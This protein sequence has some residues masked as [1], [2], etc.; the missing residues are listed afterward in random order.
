M[1]NYFNINKSDLI[2]DKVI[3]TQPSDSLLE[4]ITN[5]A[6]Q[7][8]ANN[9]KTVLRTSEELLEAQM[10]KMKTE[11]PQ[12]T[13]KPVSPSP[14]ARSRKTDKVGPLEI[15]RNHRTYRINGARKAKGSSGI[16]G[17]AI[18]GTVKSWA[19][20]GNDGIIFNP[21]HGKKR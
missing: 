17:G 15:D 16:V 18:K 14:T 6:R 3:T 12:P 2:E 19:C 10:S 1:A 11:Q 8:N 7:L 5:T 9:K 20:N 21:F 13:A 4:A